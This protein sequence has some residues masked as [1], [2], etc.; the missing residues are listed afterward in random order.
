[1]G[2]DSVWLYVLPAKSFQLMMVRMSKYIIDEAKNNN[3]KPAMYMLTAGI[4][5]GFVANMSKTTLKQGG[6]DNESRVLRERSIRD[7]T[8]LGMIAEAIGVDEEA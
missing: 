7:V 2:T 6:E 3:F 8:G 5:A 1:M 4:G